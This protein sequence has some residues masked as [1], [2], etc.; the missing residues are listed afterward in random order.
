MDRRHIAL[1]F[2]RLHESSGGA[3]RMIIWL[4]N[5]LARKGHEVHLVSW[6]SA[7]A[8]CF[9]PLD[10]A[11]TWHRLG[12]D[13]GWRDKIRRTKVLADL[14]TSLKTQILIG[15]VMS[16]DK[17]VYAACLMAGAS[18][19]AAERNSPVMYQLKY[20]RIT[21]FSYM[22]LLAMAKKI[23]VQLEEYKTGY[24]SWLQ[25]KI[26]TIGNPVARPASLA[27]PAKRHGTTWVLLCVARFED[28]KNI[29]ALIHAFAQLRP[30]FP[31]WTLRIVGEGFL[32]PEL[33]ASIRQLGLD[34][35]VLLISPTKNVSEEYCQAHL[36]CL[37]SRWEGFP[38]AL[39]E[40]LAHGL[41]SVGYAEC[42]GVKSLIHHGVTG[43]LASGNGIVESLRDCL[44]ELMQDELLRLRFG[45]AAAKLPANFSE[46]RILSQ[47]ERA[48]ADVSKRLE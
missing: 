18:I 26:V 29:Q 6:D 46:D 23:P 5:A 25:R 43:A 22:L 16:T 36:F 19:I 38:N 4:A 20:G 28:Q 44:A 9:Y 45:Q 32:K 24:P 37:P 2:F 33:E 31:D 7:L 10:D 48:I 30:R 1:Y 17:T 40:A 42:P 14:L 13:A 27:E 34:G 41:P 15:F 39:A 11:V 21:R 47:W 3:E 12:F 35:S 8:T